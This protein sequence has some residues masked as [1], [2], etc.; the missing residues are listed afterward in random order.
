MNEFKVGL[1]VFAYVLKF[2]VYEFVGFNGFKVYALGYVLEFKVY[3]CGGFN[4]FK[5]Y[6]FGYVL[7]NMLVEISSILKINQ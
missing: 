1:Y 7:V 2:K 5:V 6:V 4:G 3:E